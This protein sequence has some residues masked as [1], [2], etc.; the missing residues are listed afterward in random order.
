MPTRSR[1][2]ARSV[3]FARLGAEGQDTVA[4]SHK[5]VIRVV[6]AMATG[7]DMKGRQPVKLD[8]QSM[9]VFRAAADGSVVIERLNLPLVA[10]PA[11]AAT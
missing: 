9:H 1:S 11:T 10:A 2:C 3:W 7:W 8:W 5:G 4:V 6:L